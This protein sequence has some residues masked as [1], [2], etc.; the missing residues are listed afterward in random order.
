[1]KIVRLLF[2]L[3]F[4][5]Y[6]AFAQCYTKV[7]TSSGTSVARR[8]DGTLWAKGPNN[9]GCAGNGNTNDLLNYTQI[10]TDTD[11]SD[12]YSVSSSHVL[13]IKNNGTLWAWGSESFGACGNGTEG[14]GG[15]ILPTQI[16][17]DNWI[18]VASDATNSLGVKSDGTLWAWGSNNYG[19]IG[20]GS[21]LQYNQ[22][23][24]L[25]IGTDTNW[26]KV[27]S[28]GATCFAI[29]IEGT[30]WS[31]GSNG[32]GGKL[33]YF[34]VNLNTTRLSPHI[35]NTDTN[36]EAV[37]MD[38]DTA[39]GLKIDGTVWGWGYDAGQGQFGNGSLD[40]FA[41]SVPIQI[42][43]DSDWKQ[44]SMSTGSC[45]ALKNNGT[46]WGWGYNGIFYELGDGT[47]QVRLIPTQLDTDTDWMYVD[48][49]TEYQG[50]GAN[51]IKENN[52]LF[53]WAYDIATNLRYSMPTLVG[54]TCVLENIT[55]EEKVFKVYPNPTNT[56]IT[57]QFLNTTSYKIQIYNAL[58]QIMQQDKSSNADNNSVKKIDLS[59][60]DKGMYYLS[61]EADGQL[62]QQ[63]IIKN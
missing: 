20:I 63:K 19:Q 59:V 18:S 61:I 6:N 23:T 37:V 28:G 45:V 5:N 34:A 55:F 58:G 13:A 46:R 48:M 56:F 31:W 62:Y 33:G 22:L 38:Y 35:V 10:G 60:Y 21:T 57:I 9:G 44:V 2:V 24:P 40:S 32:V 3:I 14:T 41:T 27:F 25:Q 42:G 54:T 26:Q 7:L 1:M 16:G 51:A 30:L 36:W 49:E 15:H 39:I 4:I 17:V 52:S 29:K 50:Y 11:W 47:T 43:T 12:N 8:T 53:H